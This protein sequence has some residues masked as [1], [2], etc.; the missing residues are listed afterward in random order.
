MSRLIDR[1]RSGRVLL[2]DGAMGTELLRAGVPRDACLE[3]LNLTQPEVVRAVHRAYVQAGADILLAHTFRANPE[4]LALHHLQNKNLAILEIALHLARDAAASR[5]VLVDI[6]PMATDLRAQLTTI[7]D[8]L[9]NADGV[10]AETWSD[11]RH[12]GHLSEVN[13]A[14]GWCLPLLISF[15]YHRTSHGSLRTYQGFS[16]ERC[17]EIVMRYDG[18][19]LGVNC[20]TDIG[21][22]ELL[23]ILAAYRSVTDLPLFVRPNAGTPKLIDGQWVYP[24]TPE[25]MAAWLPEVFKA[26]VVMVGGCC[27]TTPAHIAAFRKVVD[28]WNRS[29]D[30]SSQ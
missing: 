27:G 7:F 9:I 19:A 22:P 15:S 6:G 1:L 29:H 23:E 14:L 24:E 17:A 13:V 3:E 21:L 30:F 11:P 16:P 18:G 26:G 12:F 5:P 25:S 28:K 4:N 20:G 8:G 2:M 10:L